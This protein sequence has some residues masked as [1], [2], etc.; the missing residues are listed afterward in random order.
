MNL[1]S[2]IFVAGHRGLVGS[3]LVRLLTARGFTNIVTRSKVG[4]DLTDEEQVCRFFSQTAPEYV[5]LAAAKVGGILSNAKNEATFLLDN[6]KIQNSVISNAHRFGT[7]KLLFLGSAC[8]YPRDAV[9]PVTED[10]LL[11]GPLESSNEWYAL[12]KIAGIKLCQAF[13]RQ[14]GSDFITA[15]P[16]NLYGPNDHYELASC[17]VLPALIRRFHEAKFNHIPAVTCLGSGEAR[18]EFLFS[19]DLAEACLILMENYSGESP[20]N[21]GT[22]YD[23]TIRELAESIADTV[24][25]G[26]NIYWDTSKPDGTPSR[27][28][29]TTKISNTGWKQKVF[30]REGLR[31]TYGDFV[32]QQLAPYADKVWDSMR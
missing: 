19:D 18:R 7:K 8:I 2:S 17:H 14:H 21:I 10:S 9:E 5:F 11:T 16:V 27:L 12:A 6:L 32:N 13:R 30:L 4:L 28:L 22:G 31:R 29:D 15:Q 20:V 1:D 24:G 23:M 25:F 3:A 26:G